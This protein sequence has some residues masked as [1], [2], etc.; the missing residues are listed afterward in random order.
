SAYD[1]PR[2]AEDFLR[3]LIGR[4]VDRNVQVKKDEKEELKGK[5][6]DFYVK[7]L[8]L[9]AEVGKFD[10]HPLMN[11]QRVLVMMSREVV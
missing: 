5:I 3:D 1:S 11:F 8:E 2:E 9:D 4:S 10:Q 6:V 7:L